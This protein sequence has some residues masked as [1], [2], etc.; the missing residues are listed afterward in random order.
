[1]YEFGIYF[2]QLCISLT[3]S[4][5]NDYNS[6]VNSFCNS[7]TYKFKNLV[8]LARAALLRKPF[9]NEKNPEE[10]ESKK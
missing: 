4:S 2:T 5:G 3:K 8:H 10:L 6:K 7:E 1:M 9:K